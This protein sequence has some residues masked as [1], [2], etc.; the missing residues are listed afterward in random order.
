ML[1]PLM[2]LLHDWFRSIDFLNAH[3]QR[4]GKNGHRRKLHPLVQYRSLM[5]FVIHV[6]E[7]A[8]GTHGFI[9]KISPLIYV[10][11]ELLMLASF[12]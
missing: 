8:L 12:S 10:I 3:S 2:S 7:Y 6:V 4:C 5:R 11:D 1:I 9:I